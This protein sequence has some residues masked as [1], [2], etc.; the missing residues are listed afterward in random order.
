MIS[1]YLNLTIL[2]YFS[3]YFLLVFVVPTIRISRKIGR[4][5]VVFPNDRSPQGLVGQYFRWTIILLFLYSI[6]IN[7]VGGFDFWIPL[8]GPEEHEIGVLA[9]LGLMLISLIWTIFAQV[10][11]SDA[12]RI[13]LDEEEKTPLV[14]RGV[15][16]ISRNPV[17]L[18]LLAGLLG[19]FIVLPDAIT[20]LILVVSYVLIR[21]QIAF[22][23]EFL[24]RRHGEAYAEYMKKVRRFI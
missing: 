20:L 7:V 21:L 11:M 19:L 12:W 9:G 17:F 6:A 1:E 8:M 23:E 14:T 15:F 5:A 24:T 10:Q 2:I 16:R 22:E 3:W 4:N 18:G 13:G